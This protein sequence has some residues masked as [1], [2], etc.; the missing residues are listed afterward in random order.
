VEFQ[1]FLDKLLVVTDVAAFRNIIQIVVYNAMEYTKEGGSI[2]IS[3]EA[4]AASFLFAVQD[5]GIGIPA[6]EQ[7]HIFEK[8]VRAA[9]ARLFKTDGT[10][11]GL[12]TVKKAVELLEGSIR[13]ESEE[14][15]GSI[16]YVELPLRVEARKGEV[17]LI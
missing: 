3:L 10:G 1:T 14:N 4:K 2:R 6:N 16:F 11:L 5:S 13:F 12:Y 17:E 9:N 8:F 7:E 15:K